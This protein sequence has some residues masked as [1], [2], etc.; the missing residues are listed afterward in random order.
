MVTEVV[1]FSFEGRVVVDR[2]KTLVEVNC[3]RGWGESDND[4]DDE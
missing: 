4:S 2:D 3:G 1:H